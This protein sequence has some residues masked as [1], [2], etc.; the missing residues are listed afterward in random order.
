VKK[1][2]DLVPPVSPIAWKA[3]N[4]SEDTCLH[5]FRETELQYEEIAMLL[6]A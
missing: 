1:A 2:D 3:L 6:L 5:L 4:L